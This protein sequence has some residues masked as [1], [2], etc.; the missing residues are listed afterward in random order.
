MI[1]HSSKLRRR[2]PLSILNWIIGSIHESS[3][4]AAYVGQRMLSKTCRTRAPFR[5]IFAITSSSRIS[6]TA[7]PMTRIGFM[8]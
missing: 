6:G 5:P 7:V 3:P 8:S 4:E 2:A 1:L